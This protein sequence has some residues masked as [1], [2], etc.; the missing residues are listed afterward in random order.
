MNRFS[1]VLGATLVALGFMLVP[2]NA[3]DLSSPADESVFVMG[4]PFASDYFSDVVTPWDNSYESNFFVGVG[5]QRFIHEYSGFK[6][7]FEG[8][9]GLRAS[10]NSSVELWGG[11]VGR[12]EMFQVGDISITPSITAGLS[13]VTD[14]IGVET[15]RASRISKSVPVLFYLGP[16]I[17]ISNAQHPEYE[18]FMRIQ[19]RSGGFGTIAEIDGSN[20]VVLGLRYKL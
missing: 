9:V 13:M 12:F 14:T 15:E 4:G 20:S 2:A 3:R 17:A 16:E 5:Y 8:G 10:Y 7:G 11:A 18:G 6:F 19:H 1:S